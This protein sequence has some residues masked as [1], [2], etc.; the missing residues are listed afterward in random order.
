MNDKLKDISNSYAE[1]DLCE[2]RREFEAAANSP[3]YDTLIYLGIVIFILFAIGISLICCCCKSDPKKKDTNERDQIVRTDY[4]NQVVEIWT[5]G[6][7][8]DYQFN[9]GS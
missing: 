2:R 8:A 9:I 7:D 6:R 3:N 4:Q 5:N 1:V